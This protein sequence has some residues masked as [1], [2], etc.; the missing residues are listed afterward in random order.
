[1]ILAIDQGTTGTTCLVVDEEL[2]VHRRG[3]I[4][5]RQHFPQPGW[6]EHDPEEIWE[7]VL[8]PDAAAQAGLDGVEASRS[9]ISGRRR[10][11][12]TAPPAVRSHPRSC[13]RTGARPS[14]AGSST[15]T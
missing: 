14:G 1:M 9:R 3:Y 11:S 8:A 6:V 13:G 10:S 5:L 2:R 12:G 15:R 7:S 4:E